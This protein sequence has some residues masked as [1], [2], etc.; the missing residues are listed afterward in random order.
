MLSHK[1]AFMRLCGLIGESDATKRGDLREG[2]ALIQQ[3][4]RRQAHTA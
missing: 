4:I 2:A 3:R 1:A